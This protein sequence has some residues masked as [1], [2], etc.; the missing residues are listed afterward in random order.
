MYDAII[1]DLL[2]QAL[3]TLL[4]ITAPMLVIAIVVGIVIS[5]IQ[6]LTSIQ[7]QTFSF[8]P[9]LIAI[10]LAFLLSFPW[11]IKILINFTTLLFRDFTPFIK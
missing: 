7:D 1:F 4:W 6:N 10:F 3:E 5:L 11:I 2:R 8:V 9:R